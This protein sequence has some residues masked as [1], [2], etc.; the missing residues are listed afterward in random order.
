MS[1]LWIYII[2]YFHQESLVRHPNKPF[3]PFGIQWFFWTGITLL[4]QLVSVTPRNSHEGKNYPNPLF[5][6]P[7]PK[8]ISLFLNYIENYPL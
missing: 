6:F 3:K 1:P 8:S 2:R 5:P 4:A 7:Y